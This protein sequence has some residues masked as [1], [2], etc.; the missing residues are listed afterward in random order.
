MLRRASALRTSALISSSSETAFASELPQ[1][2]S[3]PLAAS[4]LPAPVPPSRASPCVSPDSR[5]SSPPVSP[6]TTSPPGASSGGAVVAGD[7][8]G[9]G[10]RL[11]GD[12]DGDEVVALFL[13][14]SVGVPPSPPS[15]SPPPGSELSAGGATASGVAAASGGAS[16]LPCPDGSGAVVESAGRGSAMSSVCSVSV[17]SWPAARVPRS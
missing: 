6:G 15:T 2:P 5:L 8:D 10:W 17:R 7:P 14:A 13:L 11:P 1:P 9:D 12:T 4:H 16:S 3:S